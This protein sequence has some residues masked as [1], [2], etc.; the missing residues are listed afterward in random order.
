MPF[1]NAAKPN[2]APSVSI[3]SPANNA[4]FAAGATV[5]FTA[6]ASD[7][8]GSVAK[9]EYFNGGSTLLGT[10]TV[11]PYAVPAIFNVPGAY[12]ITARATDNLGAT[13][14]STAITLNIGSPPSVAL[15]APASGATFSAPATISLAATASDADGTIAKVEFFQGTTLL[16]TDTTAPYAMTWSN[17]AAGSY[18]L[19]ARA[20]DNSGATMTSAPISITVGTANVPPLV[21]LTAPGACLDL[22]APASIVLL[23]DAVDPDGSIA[24]VEFL[25]GSTV[26]GTSTT[27]PFSATWTNVPPGSYTLAARATDQRGASATSTAIDIDVRPANQPPVAT[28]TAPADGAVFNAPSSI[29]LG[30]VAS[31]ADGSVAKV[32]FVADGVVVGTSTAAPHQFLWVNPPTGT[33][34]LVA[35]ATDAAGATGNSAPAR[36]T[37]NGPP[38]AQITSPLA[39]ASYVAPATIAIT[40]TASATAGPVVKLEFFD[41]GNLVGTVNSNAT[42]VTATFDYPNVQP[43][44]HA[45]TVKVTDSAGLTAVSAPRTIVVNELPSVVLTAPADDS[46]FGIPGTIALSATASV[47]YGAIERVQ[48]LADDVIVATSSQPPYAATWASAPAG[49]HRLTARAI[50]TAGLTTT[51]SARTVTLNPVDMQVDSPRESAV[52]YQSTVALGGSFAGMTVTGVT[53]NGMPAN[54]GNRTFAAIVPLQPGANTLTVLANT[55]SGLVTRTIGVTRAEPTARITSVVDGQTIDD[56]SVTIVGTASVP[57][58][59]AVF[60]NGQLATLTDDGTFFVNNFA[61]APGANPIS[62]ALNT[63]ELS[64][65]PATSA[66]S[67]PGRIARKAT[68]DAEININR[69]GLAPFALD[70]ANTTGFAPLTVDV[71]LSNRSAYVYDELTIDIDGNGIV[72]YAERGLPVPILERTFQVNYLTPGTYP[73]TLTLTRANGAEIIYRATRMIH[74]QSVPRAAE[75]LRDIFRG[76][77]TAL[78]AGDTASAATWLTSAVRGRYLEAFNRLVSVLPQT[79]EDVGSIEA[80]VLGDGYGELAVV[81]NVDGVMH[82]FPVLMIR[83]GDGLWRI[84]GM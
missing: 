48:F 58:N 38:V 41:G 31:D 15:S 69:G 25:A 50:T 55:S 66:R 78:A 13:K 2:Q 21:V 34:Q 68:S 67:A 61:L 43:G 30:A 77:L 72:D 47:G 42:P 70:V 23:A 82:R 80:A 44:S 52:Y 81:R 79:V 71:T 76:M 37:V 6:T 84:D 54:V 35:R 73:L 5:T 33:H 74:V 19:T 27:P 53:V 57:P 60:V 10:A 8:D 49:V 26:V 59:S 12:S 7:A 20:T 9:V 24:R 17:V 63:P 75:T 32:D 39:G 65:A 16:G 22:V 64:R 3:A 46:R 11:A 40:G 29:S 51:S 28:L 18:S 83:D 14:V 1:A 4:S 56:D 45:L 36:I 62:V